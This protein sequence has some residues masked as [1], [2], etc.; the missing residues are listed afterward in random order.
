[1]S[2]ILC[3]KRAFFGLIFIMSLAVC[4]SFDSTAWAQAK[5]PTAP[6]AKTQT[7]QLT[8]LPTGIVTVDQLIAQRYSCFGPARID[9]ISPQAIVFGGEHG[10]TGLTINIAGKPMTVMDEA[11]N[12]KTVALRSGTL[13]TVCSRADSVMV[14]VNSEKRVGNASH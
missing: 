4:A 8:E 9:S 12:K 7:Q 14:Y 13:V 6:A 11:G 2:K 1:M 10:Q 3:R 5:P